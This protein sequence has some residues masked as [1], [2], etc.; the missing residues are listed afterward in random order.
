M[1]GNTLVCSTWS[2]AGI[3]D[4]RTTGEGPMPG[5]P[6]LLRWPAPVPPSVDVSRV[7]E[8]GKG[9]GSVAGAARGLRRRGDQISEASEVGVARR[10]SGACAKRS[11]AVRSGAERSGAQVGAVASGDFGGRGP[12]GQRRCPWGFEEQVDAVC[13][14]SG[15]KRSEQRTE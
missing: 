14:L 8:S 15:V 12:G 3:V 2:G 6:R 5:L 7:T 4:D 1:G 9:L 10:T 11:G 13:F